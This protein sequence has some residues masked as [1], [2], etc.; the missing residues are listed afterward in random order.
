[1]KRNEIISRRSFFK[2]SASVILPTLAVLTI[3][4]VLT[5][6]EID[7][8]DLGIDEPTGCKNGCSGKCSGVCGAACQKD[9]TGSCSKTCKSQ[10]SNQCGGSSCRSLC[11]GSNKF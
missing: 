9:C 10:C 7:E 3:P 5:S 2:R 11:K 4:S 1:M 8:E 6:C